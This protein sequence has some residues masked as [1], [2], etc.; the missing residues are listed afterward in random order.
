MVS[1]AARQEIEHHELLEGVRVPVTRIAAS[2]RKAA[3]KASTVASRAWA[4][5]L[6]RVFEVNPILCQRCGIEMVPA[7]VIV[8]DEESV[9]LLTHLGLPREPPRT[10]P[11]RSPPLPLRGEESRIDP[12]VDAFDGVDEDR[13]WHAA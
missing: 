9:R 7:A 10:K 4:A 3:G 6:Q 11:A 5:C 8:N 1:A 2:M 12:S 13:G